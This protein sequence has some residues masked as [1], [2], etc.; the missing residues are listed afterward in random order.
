MH[1]AKSIHSKWKM[2]TLSHNLSVNHFF[3]DLLITFR[4]YYYEKY[5]FYMFN[6]V[7]FFSIFFYITKY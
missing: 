4:H 1:S 3:T 7:D 5:I 2:N 6:M